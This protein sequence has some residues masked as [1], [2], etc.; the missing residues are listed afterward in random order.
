MAG[1]RDY[2]LAR[3]AALH[4]RA[5]HVRFQLRRQPSRPPDDGPAF[6][7]YAHALVRYV[8][9]YPRGHPVQLE[10]DV[11]GSFVAQAFKPVVSCLNMGEGEETTGL[12]AC[13]TSADPNA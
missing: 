13:A 8:I 5:G 12:T 11:L 1:Q 6:G 10:P 4:A 7:S 9:Q 2:H 3:R